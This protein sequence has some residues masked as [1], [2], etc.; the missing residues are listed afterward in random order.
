MNKFI[1]I[2]NNKISFFLI[3][4]TS[5]FFTYYSGYRGV[6]PL[7]SFLIFDAGYKVLN[8]YHPF[9]DYWSIT[10][11]FLDYSQFIIFKFF[12]ISWSTYIFH[13]AFINTLFSLFSFIFFCELGLKK[14]FSLIYSISIAIL[15]YPSAGSPFMDHHAS[16]F[17]LM[18]LMCLILALKKGNNKYWFF[19]LL[20][21][22]LS[23]LSKQIPSSY[24][25]ITFLISIMIYI[26]INKFNRFNFLIYL[27]SGLLFI[28]T[29]V[30]LII[31]TNDIP[32]KNILIQYILYPIKI[33]S[34]RSE[35]LK[36]GIENI[37]FQFK[38]IYFALIPIVFPAF[39]LFKKKN[40]NLKNK[41]D[42][43]I[44]VT[45][46]F[47]ILIFIYSQLLTK[48]QILIFFLIPFCIGL[49]H[50]FFLNYFD[51]RAV[52]YFFI[53]I[54]LIS[55]IKFHIRFNVEKKFMELNNINIDRAI[56]ARILDPRLSGLKW[57]SSGFPNNTKKE[58]KLLKEI[59]EQIIQEKKNKI[60]I[61]DYQ[62]LPFITGNN[63]FAPNKWFDDLSVPNK[64]NSYFSFYKDFFLKKIKEENIETLFIVG[65]QKKNYIER[66]Y[67]NKKCFDKTVINE[68]SY[69][70]N[71]SKC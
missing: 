14:I 11:P 67:E 17:A 48:N 5:F 1:I 7:D 19:V 36:F 60:I 51:N 46:I 50:Y 15:G 31:V 44:L 38:F 65:G 45:F 9:K 64:A 30:F 13:S 70:I 34:E 26:L 71:I 21:L 10:G 55:T 27:L 29:I 18:S 54:I 37:I 42:I 35:S 4:F 6:F 20:L 12:N 49:V 3:I 32:V 52:I 23:F 66:L 68:I 33:G 24:L 61:S 2:N 63:K 53:F 41:I 62:I 57:I 59:K 58:L 47:S 43:L 16:I 22:G 39:Y 28:S 40:K 25:G 56:D 8:N 69:K